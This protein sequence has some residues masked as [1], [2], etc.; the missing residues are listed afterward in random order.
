MSDDLTTLER[1][2]AAMS[3]M[4]ISD[5]GASRKFTIKMATGDTFQANS[6]TPAQI[7]LLQILERLALGSATPEQV[8]EYEAERSDW[9]RMAT[10]GATR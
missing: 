3:A 10:K 4:R 6:V 1:L 7:E 5:I 9:I 8:A 2:Y